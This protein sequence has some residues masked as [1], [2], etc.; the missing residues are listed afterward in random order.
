VHAD[1]DMFDPPSAFPDP[2]SD[3]LA[4]AKL[5]DTAFG[6]TDSMF[7]DFTDEALAATEEQDPLRS[8][9]W[10]V[11]GAEDGTLRLWNLEDFSCPRV[12]EAHG[13]TVNA[14][15]V[16]WS[17]KRCLSGAADGCKLW[18]LRRGICV[19]A[20]PAVQGGCLCLASR[21]M[22]DGLVVCGAGD[23]SLHV[24]DVSTGEPRDTV[25]AAH[26]GG[27]WAL[28]VSWERRQAATGGDASLKVW[29]MNGWTCLF[30]IDDHPGGIMGLSVDWAGLRV[31]VATGICGRDP[32]MLRLW[33]LQAKTAQMLSGCEDTPA[34][35]EVRWAKDVA[36]TGGWDAQVRTWRMQDCLCTHTYS[37][38]FGRVRSIAVDFDNEQVLC[39][40]SAGSL[41]LVD[42][43]TDRV[44][45]T[46]EGHIGGVTIIRASF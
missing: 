17:D 10:A 24:W 30:R 46:L 12:I 11:S 34:N 8:K 4:P 18:D 27:V 26:P 13:S 20:Y 35:L 43:R 42:L 3:F 37:C 32:R 19:R 25:P 5:D 2:T 14:L 1:A 22:R 36:V 16:D 40:S 9:I 28:E 29:D 31:L 41:H 45:Q 33:D 39:G 38:D 44:L 23:G 21:R 15:V 6:A 7:A